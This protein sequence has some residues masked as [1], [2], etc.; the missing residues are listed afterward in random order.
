MPSISKTTVALSLILLLAAFFRFFRLDQIPPGLRFDEAF[1]L[2]DILALMQ[3]GPFTIFFPANNGREPLFNY[4]STVG[5]SLLGAHPLALRGTAAIIGTATVAMIFGFARALFRSARIGW[6]AAFLC[7]I[8]VWHIYYSRYGLRVI[9]SVLLTVLTLWWFWRGLTRARTRDFI[10]A[11]VCA[12]LTVYTYL[13]GRLLPVVLIVLALAAS[14]LDRARARVYLRGLV[15]TGIVAFILFLPLGFYFVQHPDD[16]LAHSTELSIWDPNV[17]HGDVSGT[18]ARNLGK[19]GGMFLVRGD[20]EDFRNVP[21][22]PVFDPLIGALFLVGVAL[23]ARDLFAPRVEKTERLR[24]ILI[25]V[26]LVVLL[27]S[28]VLSDDPPNFTRS[29]PTLS[30]LI[31]L[32]AWGASAIWDRLRAPTVRRIAAS[33]F[34]VIA[35]ISATLTFRAYFDEFANLSTL[36]Y[37]FDVRMYDVGN[38]I[39]RNARANQIYLAPLWYQ[40]GTLALVTRQSPLKSFE[41]RDTIVLPS[42]TNGQD[43]LYAFPLEQDKKAAKLGERLGALGAVEKVFGSTGEPILIVYRVR[44]NDLPDPN[45]PLAALKRGGEFLQPQTFARATWADQIE[46]LADSISAADANQRNLEVTLFLRARQPTAD[47]TFSLKVRDAQ[48]RTWG[49]EDKWA[50]NNSYATT[51]WSPGDLVIEKFYPGLSA[52]AP[53]GEY[54]LTLEAYDPRTMQSLGEPIALGAAR[55]QASTGNLY[56]H[57]E[58]ERA[59]DAPVAPQARV[60]GFTLTPDEARAGEEFSL[61]LFWRGAGNGAQAARAAITLRDAAQHTTPLAEKKF[62]L[63]AEGRGLCTFFDFTLPPNVAPGAA[64]LFVNDTRISEFKII[65]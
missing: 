34:G 51:A 65:K 46:L 10:F 22:R 20:F 11:G 49:Q 17:S 33:A 30:V 59:L 48:G 15:L 14:A 56:E 39:N 64:T 28:S 12:A 25:A 31:L 40:Q 57:L 24:A 54:R 47:Y 32:P 23:L 41:S 45:D 44:A 16:F 5:A 63:P 19:V 35:L 13:S 36:Y 53:A 61:A 26:T 1:N 50:G 37:T 9:L 18:F 55:A 7:A 43:A 8:S 60:F 38:W 58:P 3:G 29:L 4:L 27:A 62:T 6:L 2:I 21:N 42:R 52:C